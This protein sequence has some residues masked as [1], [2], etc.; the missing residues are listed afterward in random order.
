MKIITNYNEFLNE[1]IDTPK[2][3]L[4][5]LDLLKT[6]PTE[7]ILSLRDS[8]KELSLSENLNEN[9]ISD[10]IDKLRIKFK[11]SIDIEIEKDKE[12]RKKFKMDIDVSFTIC[13]LPVLSGTEYSVIIISSTVLSV[14]IV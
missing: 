11:K 9:F 6:T 13:C 3:I 8:L 1:S 2:D 5:I 14:F 4:E 12:F 10:M 7:D